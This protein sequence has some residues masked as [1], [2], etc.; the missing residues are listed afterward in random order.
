MRRGA[1]CGLPQILL[2]GPDL[3]EVGW[4]PAR[5]R[6]G[7]GDERP[8]RRRPAL[9]SRGAGGRGRG[10]RVAPGR[11]SPAGAADR[12][13]RTPGHRDRRRALRRGRIELRGASHGSRSGAWTVD[14]VGF[15]HAGRQLRRRPAGIRRG[16]AATQRDRGVPASRP[17][18][19]VCRRRVAGRR[20]APGLGDR[21]GRS[22]AVALARP[23]GG[24]PDQRWSCKEGLR[25]AGP[26]RGAARH[27]SVARL[28]Q[29]RDLH[30]CRPGGR[31]S[32]GHL[33][34]ARAGREV[35]VRQLPLG[36]RAGQRLRDPG[37]RAQRLP[38]GPDDGC[39]AS[40]VGSLGAARRGSGRDRRRARPLRGFA[41]RRLGGVGRLLASAEAGLRQQQLVAHRFGKGRP[42]RVAGRARAPSRHRDPRA[43]ARRQHRRSRLQHVALRASRRA[44]AR[45]PGRGGGGAPRP[46]P[47]PPRTVSWSRGSA[48]L[49]RSRAT[50]LLQGARSI[51]GPRSNSIVVRPTQ[52][53]ESSRGIA[54]KRAS[55]GTAVPLASIDSMV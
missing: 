35:A 28:A 43:R 16:G 27:R 10:L 11:G 36:R 26:C 25:F 9:G 41:V 50:R 32:G 33:A 34:V 40:G 6:G 4:A 47:P 17:A 38:G 51:A 22:H 49:V 53:V 18:G 19:D 46:P 3:R 31:A 48:T 14:R 55:S 5:G 52:V 39:A 37:L 13:G 8:T 7:G 15:G 21:R 20:Y 42:P 24:G 54:G 45:L 44:R 29:R 12:A 1:S 23:A 30:P 2:S